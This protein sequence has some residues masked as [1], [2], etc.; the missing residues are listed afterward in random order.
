MSE[1]LNE[2][3]FVTFKIEEEKYAINVF[4]TREIL[5][6]PDI[7][8]VPG[9]PEMIRG[10]INIRGEVVPVLDLKQKFGGVKTEFKQDT[11][12]IVTELEKDGESIPVGLLVDAAH[13]VVT[14]ESDQ[15]EPPPKMGVFIDN[16]FILGMGK[17]DETFIIILNI[18]KILSDEEIEIINKID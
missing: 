6:V 2:N 12:I 7:T 9:M 11:A 14:L 16:N 4:K 15:I 18:D 3:Q 17:I 10:V 13:E 1:E 8:K 5:E